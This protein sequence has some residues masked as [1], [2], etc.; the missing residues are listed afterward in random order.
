VIKLVFWLLVALD[1]IGIAL[2]LLLGLAAAGPSRTSPVAVTLL[3]FVLPAAILGA[4]ILLFVRS[5]TT[6]PRLV[7]L[8]VA[9]APLLLLAGGAALA[10][11]RIGSATNAAGEMT[12]FRA[13]PERE[14][15]EAISRND[16][17]AV[18][19]LLPT[20]DVNATG[21]DGVTPLMLAVRQLRHTP[22]EHG[23]LRLL[24]QAG[25]DPDR[26]AQSEWPLA[27]AIQVARQAGIAPV[28]A[29]LDAGA[30][31]N[32][33]NDFGE[34]LFFGAAGQSATPELMTLLIDRGARINTVGRNG[35]TALHT[36]YNTQSWSIARVLLERGADPALG[37]SPG[38][39]TFAERIAHLP[40]DGNPDLAWVRAHLQR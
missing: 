36:T 15:A 24:L 33:V 4:A 22:G 1:A 19:R 30:D 34:P 21:L 40:D 14:L 31:P 18:Q 2:W 5:T 32:L 3:L 10:R 20:A 7:A 16:T 39:Q 38:G 23:V 25:A 8:A 11:Q 37:H 9:A 27:I 29:L 26:G 12:F 28:Q 6:G 35:L 13:G 17:A